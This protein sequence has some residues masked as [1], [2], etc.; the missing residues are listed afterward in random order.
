M[1]ARHC[2][3]RN[4]LSTFGARDQSH[5]SSSAFRAILIELGGLRPAGIMQVGSGDPGRTLLA[6][7]VLSATERLEESLKQLNITG[8]TLVT[9]GAAGN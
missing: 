2:T 6:I 9:T 3:C 5:E 7:G 1:W 8:D 4:L